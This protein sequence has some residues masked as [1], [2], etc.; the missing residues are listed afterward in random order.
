MQHTLFL[1]LPKLLP[2]SEKRKLADNLSGSGP[3][4]PGPYDSSRKQLAVPRAGVEA[5]P[6][7]PSQVLFQVACND[8]FFKSPASF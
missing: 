5:R 6:Y 7:R 3:G 1:K 4:M 8:L 2:S